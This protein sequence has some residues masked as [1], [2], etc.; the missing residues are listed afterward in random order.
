MEVPRAQIL[1]GTCDPTNSVMN[2]VW[3]ALYT[4]IHAPIPYWQNAPNVKDN[5]ALTARNVA[6]AKFLRAWAYF[7][8][9]I[10]VGACSCL[11]SPGKRVQT[12]YQ[13]RSKEDDVYT[14]IIQDLTDAAAALPGKSGMLLPIRVVPQMLLPM[15]YWEGY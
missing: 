13:P 8:L 11:Y 15:H 6:E 2:S 5:A 14:L 1:N 7:D 12:D 9:G 4:T 3:N 10:Y